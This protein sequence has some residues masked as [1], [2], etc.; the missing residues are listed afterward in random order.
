MKAGL[1]QPIRE[2]LNPVERYGVR[3]TLVALA[4]VLVAVPFSTLVFEVIAKGP[5]TRFDG[6]VANSLNHDV[7]G[8][9]WAVHVLD[10]IS[11]LGKP[12]LLG[13]FVAVA[14]VFVWW[15]GRRRLAGFLV[16]AV[17]GG[18]LVDTA[19]KVFVNR[20]RP[21]V[22]HPI[23]TAMG[24]SFPSGHAMSSFITYGALLLVLLPAVPKAWRRL[25]VIATAVLVLCIG[26]SRLLL[27]VHFVS[28]V[29][30][31]WILGAAWLAGATAAFE[32]WREEE[33]RRPSE[34]LHEGVEPEAAKDLKV[35]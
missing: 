20:P 35:N 2:R 8:R 28:D 3:L 11:W 6:S 4:I 26:M 14:A 33:G 9:A 32:V 12:I 1:P 34:P 21:H 23:A 31:G 15:R 25:T 29:V 27:G 10:A 5:L 13:A 16:V 30:G 17:I 24:K 18:G 7:Y 19:V 22:D